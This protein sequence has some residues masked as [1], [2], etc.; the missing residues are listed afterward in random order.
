MRE[1]LEPEL[2]SLLELELRLG[3]LDLRGCPEPGPDLEAGAWGRRHGRE[4]ST[5]DT[6]LKYTGDISQCEELGDEQHCTGDQTGD[7]CSDSA[8]SD[9]MSSAAHGATQVPV[10]F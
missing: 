1:L 9:G 2:L 5:G 3:M 7:P 4:L 6:D 8:S 10:F